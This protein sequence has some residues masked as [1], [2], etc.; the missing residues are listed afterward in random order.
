MPLAVRVR[1]QA[2]PHGASAARDLWPLA[3]LTVVAVLLRFPTLGVQHFWIDESVTAG[4]LHLDFVQMLKTIP[5]TESTPPL[6]YVLA[7]GWS[8]LFGTSEFALRALSAL[9]G[10][11][12]VPLL[13]VAAR[14]FA[15]R[16][17]ALLAAGLAA[18]SPVLVWY[19]QEARA[20][21]L[22]I[23]LSVLSLLFFGRALRRAD[24]RSLVLWAVAS[25]AALAT[26]Y[27]AIFPILAEAAWL[28]WRSPTRRRIALACVPLVLV[29][30]ALAPL[31]E[32]QRGQ[33]HLMF[34]AGRSVASRLLD[35]GDVFVT[36]QHVSP[37]RFATAIGAAL[38]CAGLALLAVRAPASERRA[39][40]PLAVVGASAVVVPLLLALIGYD[41]ILG[42]N[43]L[44]AWAP[45]AILG[46]AGLATGAAGRIGMVAGASLCVLSA[47]WTVAVPASDSL[48]REAISARV[49]GLPEK[50]AV[51]DIAYVP[52]G[53]G[54]RRSGSVA[55]PSGWRPRLARAGWID[56]PPGTGAV[57]VERHQP[58]SAAWDGVVTRPPA[59]PATYQLTIVCVQA[60]PAG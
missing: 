38:V 9:V 26:H 23:S 45:I 54:E 10:T 1:S 43:L 5:S 28:L 31:A 46:C 4:L 7:W 18:V 25:A 57:R 13:Y 60:A 27:F 3:A 44:P 16:R 51:V 40:L 2:K 42:R 41:Y 35:A 24:T 56:A 20:Y 55:C 15:S 6:Y 47:A 32:H 36:G 37:A 48:R 30:A 52:V 50:K 19:S 11:V 53:A 21:A 39:A 14:E 49:L 34:I 29:A 12:A 58:P 8:Q 59:Q 33:G 22:L 17:A